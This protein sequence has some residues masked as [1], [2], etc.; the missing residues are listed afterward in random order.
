[1]GYARWNRDDLYQKS[2]ALT[3]FYLVYAQVNEILE[4]AKK[5]PDTLYLITCPEDCISSIRAKE[6]F[7]TQQEY[8]WM[9]GAFRALI[10]KTSNVL[11]MPGTIAYLDPARKDYSFINPAPIF[12]QDKFHEYRQRVAPPIGEFRQYGPTP[13]ETQLV[14]RIYKDVVPSPY[15]TQIYEFKFNGESI[16]L[17][18][19]ICIEHQQ[20]TLELLGNIDKAYSLQVVLSDSIDHYK[21]ASRAGALL[22]T[23]ASRKLSGFHQE[24]ESQFLLQGYTRYAIPYYWTNYIADVFPFGS[25]LCFSHSSHTEEMMNYHEKSTNKQKATI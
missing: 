11:L 22:H 19:Q 12:F 6:T 9:V 10:S 24:K 3:R 5:E 4:Q 20:D 8:D 7:A 18:P 14:R 1:M 15:S 17:Y 23:D 13:Q 2:S 21:F 16:T 25:L